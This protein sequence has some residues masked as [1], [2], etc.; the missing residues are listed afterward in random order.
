MNKRIKL[1][2][3]ARSSWTAQVFL[4]PFYLGFLLFFLSPIVESI[5]MSMSNVSINEGGGYN[6]QPVYFDNYNT[7]F[8]KDATF[9][10]Q[11]TDSFANMLWQVPVIII[12]SLFLA[13]II[14]QK[15][16]G[17]LVVRAVFF[18][19]VIFA[20]GVVLALIQGDSVASSALSGNSV[21]GGDIVQNSSLRD[22]LVNAGLS[23]QIISICVKISDSLFSMVWRSGIQMIIFLAGLQSIP[24]TLYE[25]S[26]IEGATSWENFWKITLPMLLPTIMINLVYTII[27]TFTDA[28]NTVMTTIT[29]MVANSVSKY[30]LASAFAWIYFLFIGFIL[31]VVFMIFS[32]INKKYN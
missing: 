25:A 20:S 3:S 17:R 19:P 31:I 6:L 11:V 10:S 4:L 13:M 16:R 26:S 12:L 18:L 14:N 8:F 9:I 2:L 24:P 30:G 32:V 22:F 15:F 21:S 29:A 28:S 7:A 1:S 27:D 23:D 5:K